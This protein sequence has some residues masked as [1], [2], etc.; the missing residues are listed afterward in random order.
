MGY[1]SFVTVTIIT[2]V[3]FNHIPKLTAAAKRD[4]ENVLHGVADDMIEFI[5]ADMSGPK[6][7]R[8]YGSH[9]ASAPGESPAIDSGD[10]SGSLTPLRR[11]ALEWYVGSDV[12]YAPDLEY[13]TYGMAPRP[14][15][16][17][18]A[19]HFEPITAKRISEALAR[20]YGR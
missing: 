6:S 3:E 16:R 13:G 17:P 18:A 9:R 14:Y 1:N 10:L 11:S 15:L 12:E 8:I 20:R 2:K 19:K 5:I 7:G 4:V